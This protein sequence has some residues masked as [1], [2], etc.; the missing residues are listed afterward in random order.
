MKQKYFESLVCPGI[1]LVLSM[2]LTA[3]GSSASKPVSDNATLKGSAIYYRNSEFIPPPD[4]GM[5]LSFTYKLL[6][7]NFQCCVCKN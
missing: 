5:F 2:T 7:T 6:H 4:W 3:C 1:V